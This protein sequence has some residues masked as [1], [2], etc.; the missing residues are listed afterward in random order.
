MAKITAADVAK[1]RKMTGAGM[2]D[3]KKALGEAD[4]D[5]DAAIDML[6]KKGQKIAAKRADKDALEGVVLAKANEDKTKAVIISLNCETDF[7]AKTENFINLSNSI[8]EAALN[9]DV[10]NLE[11]LN[12]VKIGSRTISEEIIDATGIIG[13]KMQL[14]HFSQIKADKVEFYIHQD[15]KLSTMVGFNKVYLD[16]QVGKDVAMQIAAMSPAGIDKDDV[17][18]DVVKKELEIGKELAINEGKPA[19]LAEQISKG[20]LNKFF[21]ENTLLNQAFIKDN[22][23]SVGEYLK[24]EDKDLTVTIMKRH[25]IREV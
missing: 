20:R 17:S 15:K 9:S 24:S 2:M 16:E 11:E 25:S 10:T 8:L 14:S 3:C 6:R 22:K 21:K 12:N 4:G 19:K 18:E 1:L 5:F 23:K 13:E 7:V